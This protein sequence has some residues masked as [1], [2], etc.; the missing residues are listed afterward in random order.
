MAYTLYYPHDLDRL[1][2]RLAEA[3]ALSKKLREEMLSRTP[4]LLNLNSDLLHWWV[5]L[6]LAASAAV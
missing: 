1:D 5:S 6:R 4:Q 2:S 3:A